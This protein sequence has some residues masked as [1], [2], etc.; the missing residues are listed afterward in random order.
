MGKIQEKK[1]QNAQPVQQKEE[2]TQLKSLAPPP[3]ALHSS[4]VQQKE[5]KD[6]EKAVQKKGASK[7]GETSQLK[8][9]PG[10][11][12]SLPGGV[13]SKMEG[14]LGADFSSVNIHTN[15]NQAT[16]IGAQAY[17]QGND[18]HFA[19]GKFDP[20]SQGGQE[21]IGHELTH[22]VQ[23]RQ[24]RVQPTEQLGNGMGVNADKGLEG[25]ADKMGAMAAKGTTTQAKVADGSKVGKSTV[26]A[27]TE[28][29]S[30]VIKS[31][32][33]TATGEGSDSQ[34]KFIHWP[35]TAASGVTLGKGYDIG[36]RT[37]SEVIAELTAAGM[38]VDQATKVSKGAGLKGD[39]ANKF[40]KENKTAVGE[41]SSNV[42]Y[43]LLGQMLEVYTERAKSTA[44]KTTA[45]GTRNAAGREK[46]EGKEAG[47]YVLTG[48]QWSS[49]HPG[50][51]EFLTD[52]IYQG[53]YY[54]WDRVAKVN[55][56]LIANDGNHLEQFKGVRELFTSGYMDVYAGKIGEGKG[57]KG[58]K[59]N[60]YGQEVDYE[61]GYR[62][63]SIRTAYLNHIITALEAGKTV[64][65]SKGGEEEAAS[66]AGKD[67]AKEVTPTKELPSGQTAK[68][69]TAKVTQS[70]GFE[71]KVQAGES[72]YKLAKKHGVSVEA[73]KTANADRLRTWG[74]VQGFNAGDTIIIP[75][76]A[77]KEDKK[78]AAKKDPQAAKEDKAV[79]NTSEESGTDYG[80]IAE[81][82]FKALAGNFAGWGA[83]FNA[84]TSV[85]GGGVAKLIK[86]YSD[87]Y[88][89]DM[90]AHIKQ[91]LSKSWFGGV[92]SKV[93]DYLNVDT[94]AAQETDTPEKETKKVGE[95]AAKEQTPAKEE[96]K[97]EE[98]KEAAD[99][100]A[101]FSYASQRD[102]EFNESNVFSK[103]VSTIK[104]DNMC[105][106]TTLAM[107]L[108]Q[109]ADNDAQLKMAAAQLYLDKGGSGEKADLA[110][111]QL[112]DL[113]MMIFQQLGDDY[114]KEK[115]GIEPGSSYGPHQYASGLNH[116]ASLFTAYVGG[117][118]HMSS[119]TSKA[120]Y[121]QHIKP[122]M[123]KGAAVMLS[124]K[125]TGGHIIQLVDV[126]GDGLM[127]N[128]PYGM[129]M[130]DG[131]VKNGSSVSYYGK[132]MSG[133]KSTFES[134]TK[135][136]S[137]LK[138]GLDSKLAGGKGNFDHNLGEFNFY[139]W[140]EV[141]KYKIGKWLNIADKK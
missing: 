139:T 67:A 44:T 118:E 95:E 1:P 22:V 99:P 41:V 50:M 64:S 120:K 94:P 19:P 11:P 36:S 48:V 114:F 31:G 135:H 61:G 68:K 84:V 45:D 133:K 47:T 66:T 107:Q 58:S 35:H 25:E 125:L 113:L 73:I 71:Y 26:Q 83:I 8:A 28:G 23:Q 97:K 101:K 104:G 137:S 37:E 49:L 140:D 72:L 60:W 87:K 128:D 75:K 111:K 69:E 59:G 110:K 3:F 6:E 122:R 127:V 43:A 56:K 32:E 102:N 17:T 80:A 126:K 100:L 21:L 46:K 131:Y 93:L 9:S 20:S 51:V 5:E 88:G 10:S 121:D 63:N 15:S 16:N 18:V 82:I 134:R 92:L 53:G 109:L 12:N 14:A 34:T 78:P 123:D 132:R 141:T 129:R 55:E 7:E 112:E 70:Q 79:S 52:L 130:P 116:V 30:L 57:G 98:K 105:N 86:A 119:I 40:V 81:V 33:L 124:T 91:V 13:Q 136:N 85:A 27:K 115:C 4:P 103:K 24:G 74:S 77:P 62:R 39:A 2:A 96:A 106:V 138:D 65:L 42:Q 117:T 38:G 76:A 89:Q 29:D 54:G 108:L 90:V